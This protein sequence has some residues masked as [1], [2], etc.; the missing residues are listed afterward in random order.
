MTDAKA[1]LNRWREG[2]R[3]PGRIPDRLWMLA[4][5]AAAEVGIEH[6]AIQLDVNATRLRQWVSSGKRQ[7]CGRGWGDSLVREVFDVV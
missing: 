2:C 7:L 5:E 4:A 1:K 3:G 6:A